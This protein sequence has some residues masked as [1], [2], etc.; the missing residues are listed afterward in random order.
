MGDLAAS[1]ASEINQPLAAIVTN[2]SAGLRWLNQGQPDLD[3]ARAALSR[4]VR[5]GER[6]ADVIRGLRAL[7]KKT[8]PELAK[9]DINDTIHEVLALP[10]SELQRRGGVLPTDRFTGHRPAFPSPV[11]LPQTF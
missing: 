7:A 9:L 1:V 2:G 5:D 6:A 11:P 8:G 10:R 4:I 3:E